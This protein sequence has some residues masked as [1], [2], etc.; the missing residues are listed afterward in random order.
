[1]QI[2]GRKVARDTFPK[3]SL[4]VYLSHFLFIRSR[5]ICSCLIRSRSPIRTLSA[6]GEF[7]FRPWASCSHP[8]WS[9]SP[10]SS[11][12]SDGS[13]GHAD[14]CSTAAKDRRIPSGRV[15]TSPSCP[16]ERSKNKPA[17]FT[18]G[19]DREGQRGYMSGLRAADLQNGQPA[20][21]NFR[22]KLSYFKHFGGEWCNG[23]TTDSDSVCLGSN[24]GSPAIPP[25]YE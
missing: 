15:E 7:C 18:E 19:L 10:S 6:I 11:R 20:L 1:M 5:S 21:Q 16:R 17:M 2:V 3:R 24:P 8:R 23:S 12:C 22:R 25:F 9:R 4:I 14:R 13:T